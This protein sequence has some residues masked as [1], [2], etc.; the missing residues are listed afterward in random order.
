MDG[1]QQ[2]TS[3]SN[4]SS[5]G[6]DSD[7]NQNEKQQLQHD[8]IKSSQEKGTMKRLVQLSKQT[9]ETYEAVDG[10]DTTTLEDT[11]DNDDDNNQEDDQDKMYIE[12]FMEDLNKERDTL[13]EKWKQ[14]FEQ[15]QLQQ[16]QQGRNI[17][18]SLS[19]SLINNFKERFVLSLL[20][21]IFR[22]LSYAEVFISNIPLTIGA[23]G[24]SWVTQGTIWFKFMEETIDICHPTFYNSPHCNYPEFPGCFECDTS[25]PIY[26]SVV[27]FHYFCHCIALTCCVLFLLKCI[28]AW[29]V[30]YDELK[31][32]ATMT[33]IGVVCI[34]LICVSAGRFGIVGETTVLIVSAFHVLMSFWF[35]YMAIFVFRLQPD[36]SWFPCTVGIAY[37]AVK[38]WLSYPPIGFW[39]M[40]LCV[41][42]FSGTFFIA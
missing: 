27:T 21:P 26:I 10:N 25:N 12:K 34:T 7:P 15:E 38:T 40:V 2:L 23:V 29:A 22:F 6:Y 3:D 32:P 36:P 28:I 11:N 16:E 33:P 35:L 20:Q 18:S 42:Y 13:K 8:R 30:V 5:S 24:L 37:A 4:I 41:I 19:S 39:L 31:N 17:S 14:E 1:Y 9:T